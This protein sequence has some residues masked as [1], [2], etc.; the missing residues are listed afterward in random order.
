MH[1]VTVGLFG[2]AAVCVALSGCRL[3]DFHQWNPGFKFGAFQD[4]NCDPC[5]GENGDF[6]RTQA[7]RI[8]YTD[9]ETGR[10]DLSL[11]ARPAT[12]LAEGEIQYRDIMLEEAVRHALEYSQVVRDLGGLVL[13]SPT[14]L[15]TIY[16]PSIQ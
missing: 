9:V 11:T 5:A 12:I 10:D 8:E 4:K 6:Y 13:R 3:K 1:R 7:T 15:R 14:N 2:M 16:D